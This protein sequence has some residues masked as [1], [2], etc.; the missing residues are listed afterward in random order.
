MPGGT[1]SRPVLF[2]WDAA[3]QRLNPALPSLFLRIYWKQPRS[4]H[5]GLHQ[6][7]AVVATL[8]EGIAGPF[9]QTGLGAGSVWQLKVYAVASA[10]LCVGGA[11]SLCR[12][13]GRK[14][15]GCNRQP[16]PLL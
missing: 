5:P 12:P 7:R 6:R 14:R 9:W 1:K 13:R 2:R 16:E 4:C 11:A 3:M 15:R 8:V 10:S